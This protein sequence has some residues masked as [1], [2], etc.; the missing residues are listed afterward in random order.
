LTEFGLF[1][2]Q[3][4]YNLHCLI[5]KNDCYILIQLRKYYQGSD[6]LW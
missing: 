6:N 5:E 2:V 1:F 3:I 4:I